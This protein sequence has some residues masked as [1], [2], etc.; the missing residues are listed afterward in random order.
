MTESAH[1]RTSKQSGMASSVIGDAYQVLG[2]TNLK[3]RIQAGKIAEAAALAN[4]I[5]VEP[6]LPPFCLTNGPRR[7][8]QEPSAAMA[9]SP[10]ARAT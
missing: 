7:S 4:V 9:L 10:A 8:S 5:N 1:A 6:G 3:I 2:F